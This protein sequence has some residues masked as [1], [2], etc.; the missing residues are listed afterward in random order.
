M[1][2]LD[3]RK[4]ESV[5]GVFSHK[6]SNQRC[7]WNSDYVLLSNVWIQHRNCT[8]S[9][10]WASAQRLSK[11]CTKEISHG[12]PP[13]RNIQLVI[14]FISRVVIPY[15]LA[16]KYNTCRNLVS[17]WIIFEEKVDTGKH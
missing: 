6:G 4:K 2:E 14:D 15:E 17:S 16:Y 8:T 1:C 11:C 12:L 3:K 10:N 5:I 13:M 9:E 7:R